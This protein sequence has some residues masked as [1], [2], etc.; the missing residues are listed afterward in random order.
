MLAFG[1]APPV[2]AQPASA[3]S[4]AAPNAKPVRADVMMSSFG[5][6]PVYTIAPDPWQPP[7]YERHPAFAYNRQST[8]RGLPLLH[9]A[10]SARARYQRLGAQPPRR[11]RGGHGPGQRRGGRGDDRLGPAR[12]AER[13][14]HGPEDPGRERR[15][16]RIRHQADRIICCDD[17]RTAFSRRLGAL[18]NPLGPEFVLLRLDLPALALERSREIIQRV[19]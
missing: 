19:R 11:Q 14:S 9:A 15:I 6:I 12:T 2:A 3:S 7:H 4:I 1:S 13:G 5:K 16:R 8:G 18:T 10:K 17:L